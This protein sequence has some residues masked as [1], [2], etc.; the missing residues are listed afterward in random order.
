M[1]SQMDQIYANASFTIIAAA[2][3]DTELGLCGVSMPRQLQRG[4]KIQDVALLELPDDSADL[5]Y[6]KWATRGWTYQECY[7]SRRRLIFTKSQVLFLC[8]GMCAT[9]SLQRLLS[10]TSFSRG[11][12]SFGALIPRFEDRQCRF[13]AGDLLRQIQEYSKRE[14]T[15]PS[16]SLNAILGVFS[17]YTKTSANLKSPVL[18][19]PWGLIANKHE[20][21]DSFGL[22][23][24][25]HHGT[26]LPSRRADFPSWSWTGWGGPLTFFG[27][28][29]IL[30]PD[31]TVQE[32]HLSYLNWQLSMRDADGKTV[33]MYDI[34]W[35]EF[36]A[37][38][39]K[40]RLDQPDPKQL[41]VSCLVISV[42][43]SK[44][45]LKKDQDKETTEILIHDTGELL[46]C[47]RNVL[48]GTL[49]TL[50]VWR[51]IYVKQNR[52]R[53]QVDQQIGRRDCILGLLFANS[54][55]GFVGVIHD[56]LLV[57]QVGE[58]L[59]ERIGLLHLHDMTN[60]ELPGRIYVD[61]V[62]NVLDNFTI[63]DTQRRRPFADTAERRTI[64]LV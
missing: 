57:R 17:Y 62:G 1:I 21:K 37:R 59:Y 61:A 13:S 58:D 27:P 40:V 42:S 16:D 20:K 7:L 43:F 25:W 45:K 14:L 30:Q 63:S 32:G 48:N 38:E 46:S 33:E 64:C 53:N 15:R 60:L 22:H 51:G 35:K 11:T 12:G 24:F 2:D 29:I 5:T 4:V 18:Q 56:C 34:A 52:S 8:N 54:S 44:F 3:G 23:F 36:E 50:Q 41:H 39:S 19:L 28:E 6:S 55:E 10:T 49:P 26:Q 31:R 9:E 47:H